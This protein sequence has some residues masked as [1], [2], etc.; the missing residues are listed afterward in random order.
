MNDGI[1]SSPTHLE[2]LRGLIALLTSPAEIGIVGKKSD[3][4]GSE[5]VTDGQVVLNIVSE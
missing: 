5:R 4:I 3:I 1:P 2:G